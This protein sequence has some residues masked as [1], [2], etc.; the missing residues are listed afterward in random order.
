MRE[1]PS[2][3]SCF[4]CLCFIDTV[5]AFVGSSSLIVM[6]QLPPVVVSTP[7]KILLLVMVVGWNLLANSLLKS[8]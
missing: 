3:R 8:F 7:L 4:A 5:T 6:F 2:A 1:S